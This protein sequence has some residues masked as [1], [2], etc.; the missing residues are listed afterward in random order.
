MSTATEYLASA[1]AYTAPAHVKVEVHRDIGRVLAAWAELE[2]ITPASAYQTRAFVLAWLETLGAARKIE[3][4]F[5]LARDRQEQVLALLCLGIERHGIFRSAGFLGGK[6]SNFNFS[7]FRPGANFTAADILA[8]LRA[9]AETL[10]PQAPDVFHLKNQPF[11]WE[12]VQ[13]PLALLPHWP[14]ASYAYATA[15]RPDPDSFLASKLSRDT[16]KKLRKK[17][18][19]LCCL[20]AVAMIDNG[21]PDRGCRILDAFFAEKIARCKEQVIGADFTHPSMRAFFDRLNAESRA[22]RPWFELYGL[23]LNDRVIATYAGIVHRGQF[24][25]MINSFDRGPEIAKSSPGDLLLM[26]LFVRQC[27]R[28]VTSFDLGIGEA[29]YKAAYCDIV[30][31]LFDVVMG[32]G[33]KGRLFAAY[34]VLCTRLKRAIKQN[35]RILKVVR[36][37]RCAFSRTPALAQSETPPSP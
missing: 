37:I 9:G 31:P 8:L 22:G 28:G 12:R 34:L 13:N 16:R 27:Q 1:P 30:I 35:R 18:L 36:R 21:A 10:G 24:S 15:L 26:K 19:R 29:R 4:L 25:A 23:T 3:P 6:E 14:S 20:G 17:E 2:A 33:V 32:F 5:V 11:E 7:L